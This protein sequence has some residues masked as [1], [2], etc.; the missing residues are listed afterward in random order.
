MIFI[1]SVP[2]DSIRA[3]RDK[4]RREIQA[5]NASAYRLFDP[6]GKGINKEQVQRYKSNAYIPLKKKQL[7]ELDFILK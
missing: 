7:Q 3:M 2:E 6:E 1:E 5:V 4:L